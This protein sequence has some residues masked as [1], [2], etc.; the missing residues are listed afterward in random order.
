MP[1]WAKLDDRGIWID[2]GEIGPEGPSMAGDAGPAAAPQP[3]PGPEEVP[4]GETA[5]DEQLEV[6]PLPPDINVP[7]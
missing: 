3:A 2:P 4:P 6:P 5:I 1:G 7:P